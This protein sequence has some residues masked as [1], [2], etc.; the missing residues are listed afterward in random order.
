MQRL[1]TVFLLML[2]FGAARAQ[3]LSGITN[4]LMNAE[5]D[6]LDEP[7]EDSSS[8]SVATRSSSTGSSATSIPGEAS[9]STA[10]T[11]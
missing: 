7:V 5:A 3:L 1:A 2:S 4:E 9:T 6:V 11:E 8:S 10:V